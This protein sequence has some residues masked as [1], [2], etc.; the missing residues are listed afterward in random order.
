MSASACF[1]FG[2]EDEH[3]SMDRV[4]YYGNELR[5]NGYYY[6]IQDNVLYSIH[7]F[8]NNGI[9]V[10]VGSANNIVEFE[11]K[12][13]EG[14]YGN[15]SS[16][17]IGWGV[18]HIEDSV[19]KFEEWYPS[20]G[21]PLPA[22]IKEGKIV[23]DTTFHITQSYKPNGSKEKERNEWYYFKKFSS[24]PDSTNPYIE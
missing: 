24:K 6:Q 15:L 17:K 19:I 21:G 7:F 8:Y 14:V 10:N 18:F 4:P 13:K 11:N 2:G 9:S 12:L 1:L 16:Y 22:Y 5:I 3:I 23:N 20:S